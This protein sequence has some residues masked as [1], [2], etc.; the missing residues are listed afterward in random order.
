M[1]MT[2]RRRL[3]FIDFRWMLKGIRRNFK[4]TTTHFNNFRNEYELYTVRYVKMN[5]TT[6][7]RVVKN[8]DDLQITSGTQTTY[9]RRLP[10]P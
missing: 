2:P 5:N 10:F 3:L 4:S 6:P 7:N 9:T 8:G 1:Y